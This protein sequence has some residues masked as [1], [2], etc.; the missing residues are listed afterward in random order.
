MT[1]YVIT[2]DAA[3]LLLKAR[4]IVGADARTCLDAYDRDGGTG[5]D[6]TRVSSIFNLRKG[7]A[8]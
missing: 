5:A 7:D 1:E 3:F 4:G 2:R 6:S 8:L